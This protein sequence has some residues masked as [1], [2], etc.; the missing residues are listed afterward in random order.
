VTVDSVRI[1]FSRFDMGQHA[2]MGQGGMAAGAVLEITKG[3]EREIVVPVLRYGEN[4]SIKY[5]DAYSNLIGAPVRLQAVEVGMNA[6]GSTV[7]IGLPGKQV[8]AQARGI[9]FV[10]A[11]VKPFINFVWLGSLFMV[12][13]FVLAIIKRVREA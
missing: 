11:S 1:A 6:Q 8:S 9:L 12:A 7:T 4:R 2:Q 5:Q 10:E 13:G 3:S